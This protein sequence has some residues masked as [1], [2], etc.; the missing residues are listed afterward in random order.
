MVFDMREEHCT[1]FKKSFSTATSIK[2]QSLSKIISYK[3]DNNYVDHA[4]VCDQMS[5]YRKR[6]VGRAR[7]T[8]DSGR[9]GSSSSAEGTGEEASLELWEKG[10]RGREGGTERESVSIN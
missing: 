3:Y 10:K 1:S 5:I 6:T 2:V 8:S 9:G 4:L 7:H